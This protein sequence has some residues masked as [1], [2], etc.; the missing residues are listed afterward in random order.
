MAL[1]NAKHLFSVGKFSM[2]ATD[3]FKFFGGGFQ[4][5]FLHFLQGPA[6][7]QDPTSI[8]ESRVRVFNMLCVQKGKM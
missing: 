3:N 7:I 4:N 8:P 1:V 6:F 5:K 2:A